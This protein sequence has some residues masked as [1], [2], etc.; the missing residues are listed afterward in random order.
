MGELKIVS[1]KTVPY[2]RDPLNHGTPM[3]IL[4][5]TAGLLKG[6]LMNPLLLL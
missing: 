4:L 2:V 5:R 6:T 1:D 3:W